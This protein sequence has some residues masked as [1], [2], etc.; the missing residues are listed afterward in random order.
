MKIISIR[1]FLL[2]FSI[3]GLTLLILTFY[4]ELGLDNEWVKRLSSVFLFTFVLSALGVFFALNNRREKLQYFLIGLIGNLLLLIPL[5]FVSFLIIKPFILMIT[6]PVEIIAFEKFNY[7]SADVSSGTSI[8]ILSIS[9]DGYSTSEETY[10]SSVI[11]IV[12]TT[13]D[14]VRILTRQLLSPNYLVG[15]FKTDDFENDSL[16]VALGIS[17]SRKKFA[18]VNIKRE[19]Q[20][21]PYK[22]IVGSLF[23]A[24]SNNQIL[25]EH[26][27]NQ[28]IDTAILKKQHEL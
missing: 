10:Y 26:L 1:L 14:T 15:T 4:Q 22:T 3:S 18:F 20:N 21:N 13:G 7:K 12:E 28:N 24:D 23:F 19:F 16:L 11:G 8:T 9:D 25:K 6:D 5:S 2:S 27:L 17:Y